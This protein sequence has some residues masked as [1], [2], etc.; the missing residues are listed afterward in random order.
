MEE[1]N[2]LS[3]FCSLED[4]F[5]K[6][7]DLSECLGKINDGQYLCIRLDGIGLSKKYLKN[8]LSNKKFDGAMWQAFESTYQVLRRKAPTDAQNIFL[9]AVV[10][11]DEISIILNSQ[12]NYFDGR[13]FKTVTTIASTFSSFFTGNGF[14]GKNKKSQRIGGAFDGRPLVFSSLSEVSR[15]MSHRYAIYVR[16]SASKALRLSGV[17]PDELYSEENFNNL[18]YY[19]EKIESLSI[20]DLY[21]EI[22]S[23]PIVFIP[24]ESGELM[25]YRYS[26]VSDFVAGVDSGIYEFDSWLSDKCA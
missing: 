4:Y 24:N 26:S 9:A 25:N 11:S 18:E 20:H 21:S 8:E 2:M 12:K 3:E 13:L 1:I 14:L 15:Y 10:C 19:K 23:K 22:L 7:E 6:N 16:N 5:K 17:G